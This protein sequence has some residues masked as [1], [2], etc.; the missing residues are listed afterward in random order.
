MTMY[1]CT[2]DAL[3]SQGP[4]APTRKSKRPKL[5]KMHTLYRISALTSGRPVRSTAVPPDADHTAAP[6]VW[7]PTTHA[8]SCRVHRSG[9][10]PGRLAGQR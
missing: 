6:V 8:S 1:A 4:S 5:N 2:H 3:N 9:P 7:A 10:S